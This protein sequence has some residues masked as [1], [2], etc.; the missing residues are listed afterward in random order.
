[1]NKTLKREESSKIEQILSETRG[2]LKKNG[3]ENQIMARLSLENFLK[4][5]GL[6]Q[7][8][9]NSRKFEKLTTF[10]INFAFAGSPIIESQILHYRK[11]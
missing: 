6:H 3:Y 4:E 2:H 10:Y 11:Q 7:V 5:M 9:V 8:S 1:M